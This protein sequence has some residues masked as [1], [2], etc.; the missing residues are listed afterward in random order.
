MTQILQAMTSRLLR[1]TF[2]DLLFDVPF[3][4]LRLFVLGFSHTSQP[5][6]RT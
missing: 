2:L 6:K 3:L 1:F 4:S 5:H